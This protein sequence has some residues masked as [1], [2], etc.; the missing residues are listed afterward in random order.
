MCGAKAPFSGMPFHPSLAPIR[1]GTVVGSGTIY[2]PWFSLFLDCGRPAREPQPVVSIPGVPLLLPLCHLSGL[3]LSSRSP[4]SLPS[5]PPAS[6]VW[7]W[8]LRDAPYGH[9]LFLMG[10]LLFF[11]RSSLTCKASSSC[12]IRTGMPPSVV[13]TRKSVV[14]MA[15]T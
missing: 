8:V 6:Q 11:Y 10:H 4:S 1:E 5:S 13:G 2:P 3:F 15:M 7:W 9:T 14:L 12:M